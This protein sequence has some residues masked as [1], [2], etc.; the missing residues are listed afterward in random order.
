MMF[1]TD[2]ILSQIGAAGMLEMTRMRGYGYPY[3][4][5]CEQFLDRYFRRCL[6]FIFWNV[7]CILKL[8]NCEQFLGELIIL[9]IVLC[10]LNSNALDSFS[11]YKVVEQVMIL[12]L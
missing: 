4:V 5:T 11:Q 6:C 8:M 1:D 2:I 9:N 10:S 12:I 3:H 7:L